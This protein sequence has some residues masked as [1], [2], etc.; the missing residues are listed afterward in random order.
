MTGTD[1]IPE[2]TQRRSQQLCRVEVSSGKLAPAR[3]S[4]CQLPDSGP[5]CTNTHALSAQGSPGSAGRP[6]SPRTR[7]GSLPA[8]VTQSIASLPPI[9]IPSQFFKEMKIN[10]LT[11]FFFVSAPP[12]T[13]CHSEVIRPIMLFFNPTFLTHQIKHYIITIIFIILNTKS[14]F[15]SKILHTK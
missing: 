8:H 11:A 4:S 14:T 6:T 12:T 9:T 3:C 7:Q 5:A 1:E 10:N 2:W 15:L 13:P